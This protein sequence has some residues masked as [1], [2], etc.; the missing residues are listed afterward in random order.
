M[1]APYY[2]PYLVTPEGHDKAVAVGEAFA[3]CHE[4]LAKLVPDGRE[5]A[6][7]KTK[8][9]E[10]SF[11]AKKAVA[12]KHRTTKEEIEQNRQLLEYLNKRP[13]KFTSADGLE[14]TVTVEDPKQE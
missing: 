1:N 7:V 6:V 14:V 12:E 4:K 8:L 5:W 11:F 2:G 9:E 13:A 10:A 3:E